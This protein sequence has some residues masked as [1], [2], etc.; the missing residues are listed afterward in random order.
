MP[1]SEKNTARLEQVLS[2]ISDIIWSY[3]VD[4]RDQIVSSYIS[5]VADR[6]LGLTEGSIQDSFER[7]L[8][9]VHSE[10]RP[11]LEKCLRQAINVEARGMTVQYRLEKAG[12]TTIWVRSRISA[13]RKPDGLRSIFGTTSDIGDPDSCKLEQPDEPRKLIEED[14]ILCNDRLLQALKER[15]H[16]Q[17]KLC[18]KISVRVPSNPFPEKERDHLQMKLCE[19]EARWQ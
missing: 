17:M 8:S 18:E 15:D 13:Y 14:V 19:S 6:M 9:Y 16:L 1:P 5:P 12:G 2:S 4:C 10:D 7:Y 3:D 11:K